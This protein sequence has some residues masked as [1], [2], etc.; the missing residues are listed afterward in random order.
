MVAVS[1]ACPTSWARVKP[2]FDHRPANGRRHDQLLSRIIG[3]VPHRPS[4]RSGEIE[5]ATDGSSSDCCSQ[6]W[7]SSFS[8]WVIALKY[9]SPQPKALI[10]P[11]MGSRDARIT[12]IPSD[13]WC[14][15]GPVRRTRPQSGEAFVPG[16]LSEGRNEPR[17]PRVNAGP[18]LVEGLV[19]AIVVSLPSQGARR[20]NLTRHGADRG[21]GRRSHRRLGALLAVPT[22]RRNGRAGRRG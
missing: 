20:R 4:C 5:T 6:S 12:Q 2:G 8:A 11:D 21:P 19:D 9:E 22:R 15:I 17:A 14:P 16:R 18:V 10:G 3:S 13:I 1:R 7:S